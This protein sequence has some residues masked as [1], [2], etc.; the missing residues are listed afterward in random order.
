[1]KPS[2]PLPLTVWIAVAHVGAEALRRGT[3]II[4]DNVIR[5]GAALDTGGEDPSEDPRVPGARRFN[6]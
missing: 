6:G 3:M 1:V 5:K 2:Y 4:G